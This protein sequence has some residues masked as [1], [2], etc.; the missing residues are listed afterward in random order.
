MQMKRQMDSPQE[1]IRCPICGVYLEGEKGFVCPKCRRGPLC[2]SH[3]LQGWRE[4]ASC[5]FEMQKK[6]LNDLKTQEHN[7]KSFLRLLQFLFLVFA[8]IFI[9]Q[10][11]GVPEVSYILGDSIIAAGLEYLG[12][13]SVLGYLLSYGLLYGQ[14][15]K[16][17]RMESE[18]SKME[19]KR[20]IK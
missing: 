4:C 12:G 19:F 2:G 6:G 1:L 7:I 11:T 9:A 17:V 18:M 13:L 3:R 15:Q 5:V 16:I 14:R 10:K 20:M 8:I